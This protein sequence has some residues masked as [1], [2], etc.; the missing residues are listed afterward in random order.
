MGIFDNSLISPLIPKAFIPTAKKEKVTHNYVMEQQ[1]GCGVR[2]YPNSESR[3]PLNLFWEIE[4]C[5]VDRS[6]VDIGGSFSFTLLPTEPWYEIV[7]G[8]LSHHT[9]PDAPSHSCE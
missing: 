5:S 1:A 4:S 9:Q 6:I 7:T 3:E 8:K 2:V